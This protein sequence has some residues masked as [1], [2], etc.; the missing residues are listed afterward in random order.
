MCENGCGQKLNAKER[1]S[2]I[3]VVLLQIMNEQLLAENEILNEKLK[4][5]DRINQELQERCKLF[6][7]NLIEH[8]NRGMINE[9]CEKRN[10]VLN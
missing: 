4:E 1:K 5:K 2:H 10:K 7:R 8:V 9:T 6:E 3:C